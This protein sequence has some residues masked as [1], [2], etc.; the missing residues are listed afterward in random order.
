[1]RT[2]LSA[3]VVELADEGRVRG[4]VEHFYALV[5]GGDHD[6]HLTDPITQ[7]LGLC[8]A[9]TVPAA[10]GGYPRPSVIDEPA[11]ERL[12]A[13]LARLRPEVQQIVAEAVERA[14]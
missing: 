9:L 2:L 11:R 10:D 12:T 13:V 5:P 3:G 14:E 4:A 6:L 1:M 7:L 8:G